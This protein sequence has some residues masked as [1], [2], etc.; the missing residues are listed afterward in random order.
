[1]KTVQSLVHKVEWILFAL[2]ALGAALTVGPASAQESGRDPEEPLARK[3]QPKLLPGP[4]GAI[5]RQDIDEK[6]MAALI[7]DLVGC[8]TRLS[9]SSWTDAQRGVGCGRDQ[10]VARFKQ[11]S[12][13]SG[14]KL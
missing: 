1:M 12:A 11:L 10:V 4:A 5:S 8:G 9:I 7:H 14:G 13:D 3:P 2:I 6:A